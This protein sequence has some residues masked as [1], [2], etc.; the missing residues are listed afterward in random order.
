LPLVAVAGA[1]DALLH[2]VGRIFGDRDAG[3]RRHHHG[4]AAR[5]AEL[6]RRLGVLVDE[7][8]LDRGL[9]GAKFVEHAGEPV[10][11][12]DEPHRE[13]IV[14]ARR[15]RAAAEKTEPIAENLNDAPAGAAEP[16][17]DAENANRARH[18]SPRDSALTVQ[19][20]AQVPSFA[21]KS[22]R[23]PAAISTGSLGA[24]SPLPGPCSLGRAMWAVRRPSAAAALRSEV[25]AATIMQ[26][27]G[28]RSKASAAAR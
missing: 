4:D 16:R 8:R 6:E 11:D 2:H 18:R 14:V 28:A 23:L 17:I 10:V 13:R 1:D 5:L 12:R 24:A 19:R 7:G 26:S 20:L 3:L 22:S 9:V 15:H 27:A 21:A 25:W